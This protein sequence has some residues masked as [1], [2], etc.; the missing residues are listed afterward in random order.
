MAAGYGCFASRDLSVLHVRYPWAAIEED[1]GLGMEYNYI[2]ELSLLK[3]ALLR[4]PLGF[5]WF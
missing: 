5:R 3:L 2:T 4:S 1:V